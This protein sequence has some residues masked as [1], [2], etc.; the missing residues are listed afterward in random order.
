MQDRLKNYKDATKALFTNISTLHRL[1]EGYQSQIDFI[2]NQTTTSENERAKIYSVFENKRK[3]IDAANTLENMRDTIDNMCNEIEEKADEMTKSIDKFVAKSA[4]EMKDQL[5]DE[6]IDT[7]YNTNLLKLEA[8]LDDALALVK[9]L[10]DQDILIFPVGGTF[11]DQ[12]LK[13]LNKQMLAVEEAAK[14]KK[15]EATAK[16][17]ESKKSEDNARID[18]SAKVITSAGTFNTPS[19][20]IA[21]PSAQI[22]NIN[23]AASCV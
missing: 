15:S 6:V 21:S 8:A 1:D 3:I 17:A 10:H 5:T 9:I 2:N 7:I 22:H 14:S 16:N 19:Q 4:K 20:P 18:T 13:E 23:S 11:A 12:Q